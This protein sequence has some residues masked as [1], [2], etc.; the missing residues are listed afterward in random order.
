MVFSFGPFSDA[1]GVEPDPPGTKNPRFWCGETASTPSESPKSAK[2]KDHEEA[3]H[4]VGHGAPRS[5]NGQH[6]APS[7]FRVPEY[8]RDLRP[9]MAHD[10][11]CS[12]RM[13]RVLLL[14][15]CLCAVAAPAVLG[16]MT[17]P[18]QAADAPE[19]EL[20]FDIPFT[21]PPW[22]SMILLGLGFALLLV[23]VIWFLVTAFRES[24][25]WGLAC[26]FLPFAGVIFLILHLR[27]TWKP[28]AAAFLGALLCIAGMLSGFATVAAHM[29]Q[30]LPEMAA[31]VA[32]EQAARA[33]A[34]EKPVPKSPAASGGGPIRIGDSLESVQ[35]RL[36]APGG[37]LRSANRTIL[38]Y[39]EFSVISDDGKTVADIQGT[40]DFRE[41]GAGPRPAGKTPRPVQAGTHSKRTIH[42][43]SNG[44]KRLELQSLLIPGKVTVVDFHARWCG[45]CKAMGPILEGIAKNDSDVFLRKVDII[46]WGTPVTQQFGIRSVPN[47]RVYD[48]QGRQIGAATSSIGRI[49]QYIAQAKAAG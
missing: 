48:R 8:Y 19:L 26:L 41:P 33:A 4:A 7:L 13:R 20:P 2:G 22:V 1:V 15:F 42:N 24:V 18:A 25:G 35:E 12:Y 45:P 9:S 23:A 43:I 47:V 36:G 30:A 27:E 16:D 3:V 11:L 38:M 37:R 14:S 34:A 32:Q 21:V 31:I 6:A 49:R 5:A 46:K 29:Q 17:P 40:T 39:P 28:G 44:G 10:L